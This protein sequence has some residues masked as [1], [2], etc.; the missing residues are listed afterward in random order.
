MRERTK[1]VTMFTK[2]NA[3][4][5]FDQMGGTGRLS[6][7]LGATGF[8]YCCDNAYVLFK[9]KMCKT[10]NYIKIT[11]NSMDLYEIEFGKI[12]GANIKNVTKFDGIYADQLKPLFEKETGLYLSL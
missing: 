6:V 2:A 11:L 5:I 8:T 4:C 9:F 7:M 3:E 12:W 1:G 10:F